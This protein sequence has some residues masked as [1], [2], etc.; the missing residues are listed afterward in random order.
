P[1]S[2]ASRHLLPA[3]G[4]KEDGRAL[5]REAGEGGPKGRVRVVIA[6]ERLP[7]LLVVHDVA[8]DISAP[9]SR[10]KPWTREEAII[11]LLRGR[12]TITGPATARALAASLGI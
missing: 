4:E 11:E 3:S 8:V 2:A 1:S 7:E 5:A 12:L 9:P 6:A 10:Q